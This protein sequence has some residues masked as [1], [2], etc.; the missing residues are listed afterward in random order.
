MRHAIHTYHF[1][2]GHFEIKM[3]SKSYFDARPNIRKKKSLQRVLPSFQGPIS[4][5]TNENYFQTSVLSRQRLLKIPNDTSLS[6]NTS[7]PVRF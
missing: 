7:I 4:I 1:N 6:I 3:M 2:I 5:Q